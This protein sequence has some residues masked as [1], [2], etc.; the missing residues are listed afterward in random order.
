MNHAKVVA[1]RIH[2]EA[3]PARKLYARPQRYLE[4]VIMAALTWSLITGASLGMLA[5]W[6]HG[7]FAR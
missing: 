5:W 6:L 2:D 3:Q 4:D 1:L 7:L